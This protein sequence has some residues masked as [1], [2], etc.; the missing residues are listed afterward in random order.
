MK[1]GP[2]LRVEGV[3]DERRPPQHLP[4]RH[5][6]STDEHGP[7]FS[8][9]RLVALFLLWRYGE[10]QAMWNS[11]L[12]PCCYR[13]ASLAGEATSTGMGPGMGATVVEREQ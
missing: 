1:Q 11:R 4:A 12:C 6:P 8:C 9:R 2:S 13:S 3:G 7:V 10:R 5:V